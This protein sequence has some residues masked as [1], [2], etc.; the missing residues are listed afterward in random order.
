MK[1]IDKQIF[2]DFKIINE[3]NE[4][5][6][7][8]LSYHLIIG[9][10]EA[11]IKSEETQINGLW[12]IALIFPEF[13]PAEGKAKLYKIAHYFNLACHKKGKYKQFII[14][15]KTMFVKK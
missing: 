10:L 3:H 9:Y 5:E 15:P 13:I 12:D 8:F 2:E 7:E 14:Y 4:D 11:N 6:F 1:L